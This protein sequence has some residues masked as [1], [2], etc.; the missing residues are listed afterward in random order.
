MSVA[1]SV[2]PFSEVLRDATKGAHGSAQGST[3]VRELF[4]GNL[5]TEQY[6]SMVAQHYFIY[7]TLETASAELRDD[8]VAGPFISDSL[9]RVPALKADLEF[10]LGPAWESRISALP[11]TAEYARVLRATASD[12]GAFV[13]HHYVRY[14]GDLSGGQHIARV[15]KKVFNLETDGV[16]FYEFALIADPDAFKERYR[17]LLDEA[18]WGPAERDRVVEVVLSAY[19]LNTR[20]FAEL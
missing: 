1:P 8:P 7:E 14:L 13:A 6:A 9:L 19:E 12:P 11:A 2:T 5:S 4:G 20:V 10:L 15:I 18:P 16:R 17:G 3:F